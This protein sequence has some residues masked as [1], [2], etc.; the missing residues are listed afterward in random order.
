MQYCTECLS[1]EQGTIEVE[2]DGEIFE[3]CSQ[4]ESSDD[5]MILVD[6]DYG[7]DR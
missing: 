4:C 3:I 6:E 7:K 2:V 1:V 5:T